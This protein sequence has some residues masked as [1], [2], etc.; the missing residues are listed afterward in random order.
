MKM[1]DE[2]TKDPAEYATFEVTLRAKDEYGRE[3]VY[4]RA[5]AIAR[6]WQPSTHGWMMSTGI[7]SLRD[8]CR[9]EVEIK[10]VQ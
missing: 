2:T 4:A 1:P 9:A 10:R 3:A 8:G 7:T 5:F 6:E